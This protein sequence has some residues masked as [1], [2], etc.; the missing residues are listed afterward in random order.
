[1]IIDDPMKG[2]DAKS[3]LALER[4]DEWY[5][6]TALTRLNPGKTIAILTMQRLHENDLSGILVRQGW[7]C[8]AIPA[9]AEPAE[10]LVGKNKFYQRP[11]GEPL[12]PNLVTI[13][14]LEA[15]K[16]EIGSSLW[17][18]QY[19]QN[20]LP[21]QGNLIK[22]EW[23][24][25]RYDFDPRQ[26]SFRHV[27]LTCDPAGKAGAHNDYTAIGIFGFDKKQ[28]HLLH[29]EPGHW[30]ITESY[31]RIEMLASDFRVERA[32]IEDTASGM[33]LIDMFREDSDLVV[34]GLRPDAD[35]QTRMER[36]LARFEAGNFL[37][38]RDYTPWLPD[39][40]KEFLA[41]PNGRHD[42]QVDVVLLFFDWFAKWNRYEPPTSFEIGLP[43][44]G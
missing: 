17:E 10:I 12:Q 27:I 21:A 25:P 37:L 30:K 23:L 31:R 8:L 20:P 39:F 11:A 24:L 13:E 44:S 29:M 43:I 34:K 2:D 41:F 35:K 1:M 18:A 4:V 42:D 32:I 33:G 3:Q 26:S 28:I 14:D 9:I 15:K 40:E 5:R 7:P 16:R 36:H 22:R 19:Q 38:P 6:N